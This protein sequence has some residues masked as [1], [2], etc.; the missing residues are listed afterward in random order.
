MA[1]RQTVNLEAF[2]YELGSLGMGRLRF[3]VPYPTL[4][5]LDSDYKDAKLFNCAQRGHQN[6]LE[7]MPMF[8][9]LMMLGGM[10]HPRTC[11]ALGLLYAVSRV[12]EIWLLG[13]VGRE[14]VRGGEE[15]E[16]RK[17]SDIC[18]CR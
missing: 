10:R 16:I 12:R 8:F 7:M 13:L 4:Y 6:S 17:E 18:E 14:K 11:V 1:T 15:M 2:V 3:N 5:A 9:T